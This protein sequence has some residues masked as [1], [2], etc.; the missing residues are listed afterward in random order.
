M[1]VH[2]P[3]KQYTG[4]SASVSFCNGIGETDN[5]HL[6]DWFRAHGYIVEESEARPEERPEEKPEEKEPEE[7]TPKPEAKKGR[8][9]GQ[10][11]GE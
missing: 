10:K 8:S 1:K 4:T 9:R 7:E 5:P 3:N 6:L 11:A 2:S